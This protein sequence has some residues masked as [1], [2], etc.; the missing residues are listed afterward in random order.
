MRLADQNMGVW[1]GTDFY[2]LGLY[3]RMA[4]GEALR[5]GLCHYNTLAEVDALTSALAALI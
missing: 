4:W 3:D 5:V 2:S 1:S